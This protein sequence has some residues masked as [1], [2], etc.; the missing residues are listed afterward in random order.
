MS[1]KH[2]IRAD[3]KRDILRKVK[4]GGVSVRDAAE[5]AGVSDATIYNWLGKGAQGSPTWND[6][7]RLKKE[8]EE[9]LHIIGDLT[10]QLSQS[11]KKS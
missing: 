9:L 3:V 6:V 4:E 11:K 1:T 5:E 7:R 2:N 8:K 10:V